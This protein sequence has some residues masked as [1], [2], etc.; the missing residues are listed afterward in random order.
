MV[1][2]RSHWQFEELGG[3]QIFLVHNLCFEWVSALGESYE[4]RYVTFVTCF[5]L[6]IVYT[7]VNKFARFLKVGGL[8]FLGK[9]GRGSA[10]TGKEK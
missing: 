7:R 8:I 5:N 10:F 9:L 6:P 4:S 3:F 1:E 2:N